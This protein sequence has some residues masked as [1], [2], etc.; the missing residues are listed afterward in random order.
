VT[1]IRRLNK[2]Q[3]ALAVVTCILHRRDSWSFPRTRTKYGDRSFAV[4]GPRIW[5][6]LP[7]ELGAPDEFRDI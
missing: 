5:N 1:L 4:Q 6:S 3:S 2:S 7:A